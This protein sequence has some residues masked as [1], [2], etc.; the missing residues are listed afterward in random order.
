MRTGLPHS[1]APEE[2]ALPCGRAPS[3]A[4]RASARAHGR[5]DGRRDDEPSRPTS[6]WP[7]SPGTR[8]A[9]P[10][11]SPVEARA[12]SLGTHG[13]ASVR[14][15]S[16]AGPTPS[17]EAHLPRSRW[18]DRRRCRCSR[19]LPPRRSPH[20]PTLPPPLPMSPCGQLDPCG[21][22]RRFARPPPRLEP[23]VSRRLQTLPQSHAAGVQT[24]PLSL[25]PSTQSA[26][27]E[28]PRHRCVARVV[29]SRR[30]P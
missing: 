13:R 24:H 3:C 9:P 14:R 19:R 30:R 18:P 28:L 23:G 1:H 25:P 8:A 20:P 10:R 22:F 6:C 16:S 12:A 2:A 29:R 17:T 21:H 5:R 11:A 26:R 7:H 15:R 27:G 4:P